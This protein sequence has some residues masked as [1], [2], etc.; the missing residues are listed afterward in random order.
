MK[1][2]LAARIQGLDSRAA[3][4]WNYEDASSN[5]T[6]ISASPDDLGHVM[7]LS[8]QMSSSIKE[9]STISLVGCEDK[10]R[11]SIQSTWSN[12][13]F[14]WLTDSPNTEELLV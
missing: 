10:I 11:L 8:E 7:G 2:G 6:S 9:G 1:G 4:L 14:I 5:P 13:G 3:S 12:G